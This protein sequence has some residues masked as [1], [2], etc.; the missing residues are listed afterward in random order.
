MTQSARPPSL[1]GSA[2][3][4]ASA[5]VDRTL[6]K[7]YKDSVFEKPASSA[8]QALFKLPTPQVRMGVYGCP[9]G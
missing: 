9:F 7:K 8:E 5:T 3:A 2:H 1:V 6:Y 4:V